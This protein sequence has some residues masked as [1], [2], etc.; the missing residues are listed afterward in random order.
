MLLIL[1]TASAAS[2]HSLLLKFNCFYADALSSQQTLTLT[3]ETQERD[4]LEKQESQLVR[5]KNKVST[6]L[7]A[8]QAKKN[9]ATDPTEE[10]ERE[11]DIATEVHL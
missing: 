3:Q 11:L 5:E 7:M 2:S 10:L 6:E 9:D 4:G 1:Y 8:L